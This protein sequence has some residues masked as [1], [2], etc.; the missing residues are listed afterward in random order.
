MNTTMI[1]QATCHD[2]IGC[3]CLH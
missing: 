2:Q 3:C 1:L